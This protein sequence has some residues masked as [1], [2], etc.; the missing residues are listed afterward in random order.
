MEWSR[1][2][3]SVTPLEDVWVKR[4]LMLGVTAP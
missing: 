1:L 4:M 2:P 3:A